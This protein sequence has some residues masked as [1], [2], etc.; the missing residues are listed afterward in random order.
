MNSFSRLVDKLLICAVSWI[1][2]PV[3]GLKG[4]LAKTSGTRSRSLRLR[5]A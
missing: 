1:G 5:L 4:Q 2:T 3:Q